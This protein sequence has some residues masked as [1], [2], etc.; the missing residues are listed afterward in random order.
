MLSEVT[1]D[2]SLKSALNAAKVGLVFQALSDYLTQYSVPELASSK[3]YLVLSV[4][5]V[6]LSLSVMAEASE[7]RI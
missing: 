7:V 4:Y 5:L 2:G 3:Y 1:L 6:P